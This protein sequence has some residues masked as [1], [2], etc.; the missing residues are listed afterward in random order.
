MDKDKL[1]ERI[2]LSLENG[3][4]EAIEHRDVEPF[5]QAAIAAYRTRV[6]GQ[7]GREDE[8]IAH[9]VFPSDVEQIVRLSL[10]VVETDKEKSSSLFK[11][12][13]DQVLNRL[14]AVAND[15]PRPKSRRKPFWKFWGR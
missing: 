2:T 13:L 8:E 10:R 7:A 14:A 6:G 1:T 4:R 15:T 5:K 12:A 11:A 3:I 9:H